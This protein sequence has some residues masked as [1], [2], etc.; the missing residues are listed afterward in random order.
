MEV[1]E[2]LEKA[3]PL[4][5]VC[6]LCGVARSSYYAYASR[7]GRALPEPAVLT[8]V[9]T[10]QAQSRHSDGLAAHGRSVA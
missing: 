6:R 8:T 1:I 3:Y 2:R 4:A 5:V 7:A 10:I 9:R